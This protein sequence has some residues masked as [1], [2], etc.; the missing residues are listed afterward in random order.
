MLSAINRSKC[1]LFEDTVKAYSLIIIQFDTWE[2]VVLK[3]F[4]KR[5]KIEMIR[6]VG[7]LGCPISVALLERGKKQF[8]FG[9]RLVE[10][11]PRT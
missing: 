9:R 5:E 3:E 8:V 7:R 6:V 2:G 4:Y 10:C 11:M 1:F